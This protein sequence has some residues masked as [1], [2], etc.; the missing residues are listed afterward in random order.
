[1]ALTLSSKKLL[2]TVDKGYCRDPQLIK[3]QRVSDW[4]MPRPSC[5]SYNAT[6]ALRKHLRERADGKLEDQEACSKTV[7]SEYNK[8]AAA[9]KS[10]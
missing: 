5:Y 9:M 4:R 8:D 7:S 6:P 3:M 1:M 2:F 10:Q